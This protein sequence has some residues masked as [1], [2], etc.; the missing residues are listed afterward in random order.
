MI[1]QVTDIEW[2][3]DEEEVD[4]PEEDLIEAECEEEIENQLSD[5]WG[6]CVEN[7]CYEEVE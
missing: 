7:F 6:W 5:K 4:L 2:D 1:F 3:T